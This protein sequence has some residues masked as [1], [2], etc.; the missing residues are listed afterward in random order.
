[1]AARARP[2][3][4]APSFLIVDRESATRAAW[5]LLLDWHTLAL[6][7]A[8]GLIGAAVFGALR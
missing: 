5:R 4:P 8:Y 1:M 2:R 7:G 6:A 3:A